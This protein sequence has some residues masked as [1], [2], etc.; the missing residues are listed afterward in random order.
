MG[1]LVI[2]GFSKQE[3]PIFEKFGIKLKES[4]SEDAFLEIVVEYLDNHNTLSLATCSED[5]PR[6]TTVE[7]FNHG[8]TVYLLAEGG[9][10]IAN[11]KKNPKVAF[12]IQDPY[13]PKE[14]YFSASG[15]QVWGVASVF[16]KND[17]PKKFASI[18]THFR[19]VDGLKKQGIYDLFKM[20]NFNVV[21]IEPGKIRYLNQ[22]QGYRR[23]MWT[24]DSG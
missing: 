12:T 4:I 17:D 24:R 11:L 13:N 20:A 10:K 5:E 7:Y 8:L 2:P 16:K 1:K 19:N 9:I 18:I 23:V 3:K 14:D 22:R 15:L 6:S 21:T